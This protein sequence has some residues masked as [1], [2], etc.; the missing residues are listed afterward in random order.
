VLANV[1]RAAEADLSAAEVSH[2]DALFLCNAV[3]GILPVRR[4]GLRE[5]PRQEAVVRVRRQLAES[6]PAFAFE[7]K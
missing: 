1:P 3:R 6:Q 4:L 2:A 5:W 7:D